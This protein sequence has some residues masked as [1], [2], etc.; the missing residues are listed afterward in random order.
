MVAYQGTTYTENATEYNA[1]YQQLFLTAGNASIDDF[2]LF[3]YCEVVGGEVGVITLDVIS[4]SATIYALVLFVI[5]VEVE[6]METAL[7]PGTD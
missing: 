3:M 7:N 5:G 1:L 6:V 4:A 2:L